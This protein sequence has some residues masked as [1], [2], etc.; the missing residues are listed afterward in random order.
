MEIEK[1]KREG[2]DDEEDRISHRLPFLREQINYPHDHHI[3]QLG[4]IYQNYDYRPA[5]ESKKD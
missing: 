4:T 1:G 5:S 3:L 2:D